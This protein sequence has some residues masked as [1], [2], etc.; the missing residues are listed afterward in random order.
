[1]AATI[2]QP[3]LEVNQHQ[4]I[5]TAHRHYQRR[6]HIVISCTCGRR[7][8]YGYGIRAWRFCPRCGNP[9]EPNR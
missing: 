7:T 6:S 2:Q 5:A 9:V 3:V 8:Y 4:N 1:M